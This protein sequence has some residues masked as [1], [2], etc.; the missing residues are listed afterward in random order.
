MRRNSFIQES[1][2]K[3]KMHTGAH[4][5]GVCKDLHVGTKRGVCLSQLKH[6][7]S[8]K[9]SLSPGPPQSCLVYALLRRIRHKKFKKRKEAPGRVAMTRFVRMRCFSLLSPLGWVLPETMSVL[10]SFTHILSARHTA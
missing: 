3:K 7:L 10:A 8:G 9:P 1:L 2:M 5:Y 6:H 4:V